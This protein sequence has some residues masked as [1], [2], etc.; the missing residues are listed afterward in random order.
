MWWGHYH[1]FS[2]DG[3]KAYDELIK[4]QADWFTKPA[5][6]DL[7]KQYVREVVAPY[8][9]DPR[10]FAWEVMNETYAAGNDRQAAIRWTNAIVDT[11]HEVDKSHLTTTSACEAT[12]AE[13]IEWIRDSKVDFFNWHA[14][15]TYPDYGVYRAQAGNDT[16]REIGNYAAV[17]A[18]A[19]AGHGK[20]VILGETGNDRGNEVDYPEFRTLITRDC[21]WMALLCGSPGGI[22]WDAIADPRE[23]GVISRVAGQFGSGQWSAPD[24]PALLLD[25][26][27]WRKDL[28][29]VAR[30]SWWA[31]EHG[32][33]R[34]WRRGAGNAPVT[35]L[36]EFRP[37]IVP[38]RALPVSEGYQGRWVR[39]GDGQGL[40]G[41]VRNVGGILPQNV[42]TR[43]ARPLKIVVESAP[44]RLQVW[45]LD[46]RRVVNTVEHKG[47]T[48]LDLGRTD[49]DFVV[50][51]QA[52]R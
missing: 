20:C 1:N 18:T 4:T 38:T 3:I 13:E 17:M 9:N 14:Y 44:G 47:Q 34:S 33:N 51:V 16:P 15:P 41:Y 46:E 43:A 27:D 48:T 30:Y 36:D 12:P 21:L 50:V 23:F 49:H 2:F 7:Q 24:A 35:P 45:D 10:I 19:D 52:G 11:M 22:S 32:I 40:I 25:V 37:P 28:G 5:A 6:L 42:R 26:K 31:L 8:A 29:M 39:L